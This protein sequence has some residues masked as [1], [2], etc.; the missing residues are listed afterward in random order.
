MKCRYPKKPVNGL[1]LIM[2]FA[3]LILMPGI[4]QAQSNKVVIAYVGGFR[5]LIKNVDQIDV[6][7]LTHIDYAFVDI[8]NNRAWLHREATDTVNFRSLVALKKQNSAL[9][10]L[11]SIGGWSWSGRF[12]DAMLS[13]TSRHGFATSA[14]AIIG[15]FNLDGI[16][17]DWEYPA[18][19]GLE[20]NIYR[21][22]DE[23]NYT[24]MFKELRRQLDSLQQRTHKTYLLTTAVGAFKGFVSHTEMGKVQQYVDYIN[25]M[26]YDYSA[27]K[28]AIHHTA[29]YASKAYHGH[30]NADDAV[31]LFVAAGVPVN[32]LVMGI[33]FY[34]RSAILVDDAKGLGDSIS[35]RAKGY[36]YTIIKDSILNLPGFNVYR[37]HHAKADY[38]Y[39]STTKQFF[40]FDDEWSVKK[41]VKYVKSKEMAGVMFWEYADDP[42]GYLLNAIDKSINK[43]S[44]K[45][46]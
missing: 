34:G 28:A 35:T 33:A 22:E 23:Q 15:K 2:A 24:L 12:S 46:P 16:D 9:K 21:P 42:K 5:G 40:S 7:K 13:D 3:T 20:G 36:G 31:D 8:K 38:I 30:N 39:N 11:I 25:L 19:K 32:K 45:T 1:A 43:V 14:V 27:G 26:T 4:I 10:I 41:K 37:D 29:L 17:I 44:Y 6:K 18:R